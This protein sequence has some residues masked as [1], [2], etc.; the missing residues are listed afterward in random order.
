MEK[1]NKY[2]KIIEK[3]FQEYINER[4]NSI[5]P[6]EYQMIIDEKR[7]HFQLIYLG[8]EQEDFVHNVVYHFDIINNKVWIQK[9]ETDENVAPQLM[10]LGVPNTDIVL[11]MQPLEYRQ[12][13]GY[14][15]N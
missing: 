8:W 11:G 3:F 15:A 1:I 2:T 4:F 6:L 12:F 7:L 10:K 9:N 5:Q 14:A 13:T